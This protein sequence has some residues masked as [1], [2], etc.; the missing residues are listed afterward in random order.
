MLRFVFFLISL[1]SLP[2]NFNII[3]SFLAR[4][5]VSSSS[6]LHLFFIS[7]SSHLHSFIISSSSPASWLSNDV[8][9]GGKLLL[10]VG[11]CIAFISSTHQFFS[12]LITFFLAYLTCLLACLLTCSL[13]CLF[14]CLL[15][16]LLACLLT[17]LLT[18]LLAYLLTYLKI[19]FFFSYLSYPLRL[20]YL[21]ESFLPNS[22]TDN[23]RSYF[24]LL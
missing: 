1:C 9:F 24:I 8:K 6:H 23:T 16:C 21:M 2:K 15:A 7:S 11:L 18:Y 12:S 14:V 5:K 13:A 4:S 3:A 22:L 10:N 20:T 19:L 17:Y